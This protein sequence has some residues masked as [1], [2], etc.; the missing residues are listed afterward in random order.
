MYNK[1]QKA[2]QRVDALINAELSPISKFKIII[3]IKSSNLTVRVV[4]WLWNF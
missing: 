1:T 4:N 3:I 2:F